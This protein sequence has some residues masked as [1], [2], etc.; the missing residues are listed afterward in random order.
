[1]KE[2]RKKFAKEYLRRTKDLISIIE[3]DLAEKISEIIP[4]FLEAREKKQ[5]IFVMGNGGSA[6]TASHF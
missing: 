4:I 2:F 3:D 5:T 1:M 6:A